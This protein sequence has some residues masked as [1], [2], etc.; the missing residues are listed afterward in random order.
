ML[1]DIITI[2]PVKLLIL[3]AFINILNLSHKLET[4]GVSCSLALNG[5]SG[6]AARKPLQPLLARATHKIVRSPQHTSNQKRG[7]AK[8]YPLFWWRWWESN[9][10]PK[11]MS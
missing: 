7:Q 9:P 4:A 5:V 8:A 6:L 1:F 2:K 3:L 11:R 10:R